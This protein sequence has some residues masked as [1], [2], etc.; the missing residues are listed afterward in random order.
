[1]SKSHRKSIRDIQGR[2]GIA[3]AV[4][5]HLHELILERLLVET[6][7]RQRVLRVDPQRFHQ[8][9]KADMYENFQQDST[10]QRRIKPENF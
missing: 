10:L 7:V 4:E 5:L 1:M 2:R 8:H 9:L 3:A 6:S